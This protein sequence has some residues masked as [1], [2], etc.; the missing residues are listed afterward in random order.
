MRPD[1]DANVVLG[2]VE[3]GEL[4]DGQHVLMPKAVVVLL[5]GRRHRVPNAAVDELD[6]GTRVDS[7]CGGAVLL[8]LAEELLDGNLGD[9]ACG[10][11]AVCPPAAVLV[12]PGPRAEPLALAVDGPHVLD[13]PQLVPVRAPR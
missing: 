9:V 12:V 10:L 13:V 2:Q 7:D 11:P 6:D 5:H 1:D 8:L 3:E 4:G